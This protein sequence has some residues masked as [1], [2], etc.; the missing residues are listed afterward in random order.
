M[1]DFSQH[2]VIDN[3]SCYLKAG[4]NAENAPRVVIP[5]VTGTLKDEAMNFF[6]DEPKTYVG[7]ECF[8]NSDHLNLNYP[9]E[10]L[11]KPRYSEMEE[12]WLYLFF[13]QLK[14]SPE[15][16]NVFLI[17]SSF[18]ND[19][20]RNALAEIMFEKFNI[21]N[22]HIEPQG[23]M[24]LWSTAK[25]S[26]LVVESDHLSTEIIPIYEKYIISHGIRTSN[27]SGL[28]LTKQYQKT[29]SRSLPVSCK[30]SNLKETSRLIKEQMSEVISD[31][32]FNKILNNREEYKEYILPD[33]NRMKIGNERYIIP[34]AMFDPE[35]L[36]IDE[37]PLHELIKESILSCDINIRKELASN[38]ILGGGNT[39]IK[40]FADVLKIK[41]E[42]ALG[43]HYEGVVKINANKERHYSVW[44]G[45]SVVCSINNF[46]HIWVSKTDF[47]EHGIN[48]F[49]KNYLF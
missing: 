41:V 22:I 28:E 3:G 24:A 43:K 45:A 5:T 37:K 46:Q 48:A 30:V 47:E 1:A 16:H 2:I 4:F 19:K 6:F 42:E 31:L 12:V 13:N 35:I 21:F 49:H 25:S 17:E 23:T 33:G 8:L 15:S 10:E 40:G 11:G 29:V 27:I 44:T 34:R 26:G 20:E 9:L 36:G 14:V 38:I 39:L 7:K 32:E 18:S